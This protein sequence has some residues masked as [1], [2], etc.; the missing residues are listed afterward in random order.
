MNLKKQGAAQ[1]IQAVY[2][3]RARK[4]GLR[5]SIGDRV[6]KKSKFYQNEVRKRL[7]AIE[8]EKEKIR[9]SKW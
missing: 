1:F 5:K 7:D 6:Y 8:K 3:R 4:F 9:L 2:R